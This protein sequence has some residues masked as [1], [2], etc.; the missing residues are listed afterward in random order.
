MG[1]R[2]DVVEEMVEWS[3]W[4]VVCCHQTGWKAA[5][6][7]VAGGC[8]TQPPGE[9]EQWWSPEEAARLDAPEVLHARRAGRLVRPGQA[10]LRDGRV[11]ERMKVAVEGDGGLLRSQVRSFAL[12]IPISA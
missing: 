3:R 4:G 9:G 6:W 10:S 12:L 5:M 8:L 11:E 1:C 2:S 7:R